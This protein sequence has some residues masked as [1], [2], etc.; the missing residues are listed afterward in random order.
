MPPLSVPGRLYSDTL[1]TVE[2]AKHCHNCRYTIIAPITP[3]CT[4]ITPHRK[5]APNIPRMDVD[6]HAGNNPRAGCYFSHGFYPCR[7]SI[8]QAAVSF[9]PK[10]KYYVAYRCYVLPSLLHSDNCTHCPKMHRYKPRREHAPN[11]PPLG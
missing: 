4:S 1:Q 7:R 5:H 6:T 8:L 2:S 10:N 9:P 3:K 11:L